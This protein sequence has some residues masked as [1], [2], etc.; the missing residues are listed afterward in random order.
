MTD[1][2]IPRSAAPAARRS[3]W[4]RRAVATLSTAAIAGL[5]VP[6][7]AAAPAVAATTTPGHDPY[8]G[9]G[10]FSEQNLAADRTSA[11]FFYRIPAL[12]SLGDGVV[13]ASWDGRP[14]SAADSPNPNS[15]VQ[16]RS[17]DYGKTWGPLTIIAAGN[18]GTD[19]TAKYG[20]S[21]PSYVVD[22][23]TGII[24]N[25][26]VYSKDQGFHNS[27][28]GNDDADRQIISAAVV[29]S[30]DGGLTWSEPRLIT[31]VAK[32]G[33]SK[34]PS[35]GD[36]R[37][38][39]AT[40]GEGIQLKHGQYAGRLIQQ[41]AGDV[42]LANG[43]RTYQAYSVYSDDHGAT[44]HRG[45]F[46][47]TAMDE[48]KV[49]E[50]SD[51]RVMLNS[52]DS[53][54]GGYRKVAISTDGGHSYGPVTQDFQ[55]PD[56]TNNAHITHLYPE[57]EAGTREAAMLLY[58]GANRAPSARENV[59]ARVSCDD[60]ATW[61]GLR[62]IRHGFSAYSSTT[63]LGNGEFGTFYEANYT[64]N[65]QF[66]RYDEAW[67]NVVCAPQ[68]AADFSADAGSQ[69]TVP[70][71]IT[72]QEEQPVGG[73]LTINAP[74]GWTAATVDVAP[75]AP[76]A[77]AV[78]DVPVSVPNTANGTTQLQTVFTAADGREA[79][80]L[81]RAN[82]AG[83]EVVAI[84]IAGSRTDTA[85]DLAANPYQAGQQVPYN[86]LVTH[87]GNVQQWVVPTEGN[88]APFVATPVGQPAPAGNCRFGVFNVGAF[89]NCSTPRHTVTAAELA[90]GFFVPQTTWTI[91]KTG[92]PNTILET[93]EVT[94]DE[95]DLLV[96]APELSATASAAELVDADGDGYASAGDAVRSTVTVEN[97]GNVRLTGVGVDGTEVADELAPGATAEYTFT[98]ALTAGDL[99]SGEAPAAELAVAAANGSL[100]ATASASVPALALEV[101][102][103]DGG[104]LDPGTPDDS[105]ASVPGKAVLSHD[106]GWGTGLLD[107][108]YTIT[109]KLRWGSNGSLFR[110]YEDGELIA[111]ER[112]GADTPNAQAVTTRI[113]GKAN[114]T[115]TYTGELVNAAGTTP[116]G[117]V[118][119]TVKDANPAAPVLSP[120]NWDNDGAYT[121]T[122][123]LWWGTNATAYRLYENGQLVDARELTAN[124]PAAQQAATTL[125]GRAKG[126]YDYVAVFSNAAGQTESKKIT[127][128]VTK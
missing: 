114:G 5:I 27:Q 66:A 96:R 85:R 79:Q 81:L 37:S 98:R 58:T 90:D 123:N 44:W 72:N 86:F 35:P 6:T 56:P 21:D 34:T 100:E 26:F 31:D 39:F 101:E 28:F 63:A 121:V 25:F 7:L 64:D 108:D 8:A 53:S 110:L 103:D 128:K 41:Y 99:E 13:L 125:T 107:G 11:N 87:T 36:V 97:T 54:N 52:R 95:V 59:S 117:T 111:V 40:S 93:Y 33:S 23:E 127:V 94:G 70:V 74:S 50:L 78:V 120:D 46:V 112:L 29:E 122:A 55:L 9:P 12:T 65:M 76:G 47:G 10:T 105:E 20:Y 75:I 62:T 45:E 18:L 89:Y 17:T 16:R 61:P 77:S 113:Q 24:F 48:N 49:V 102:P 91:G 14:G 116:T 104:A 109:M 83:Q 15:I 119:V 84:T 68:Q 69:K 73:T 51:G 106:N 43:T 19:G 57:A 30:T 1:T 92:A 126:S 22:R 38:M 88:F 60:G 80:S 82:I 4:R 3:P 2:F 32:P 124:T 42:Q 71:T 67:L 118:K 115:Y